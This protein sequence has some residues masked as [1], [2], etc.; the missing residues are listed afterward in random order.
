MKT[1]TPV[2]ELKVYTSSKKMKRIMGFTLRNCQ[3]YSLNFLNGWIRIDRVW[4]S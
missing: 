4:R 1:P 2:K 3:S